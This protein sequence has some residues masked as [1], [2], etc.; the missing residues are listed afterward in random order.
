[1][2]D[3]YIPNLPPMKRYDGQTMRHYTP[4]NNMGGHGEENRGRMKERQPMIGFGESPDEDQGKHLTEE[5]AKRWVSPCARRTAPRGSA[6][7]WMRSSSMLGGFGVEGQEKIVEF[8]A[9]I[10]AMYSDYCKVDKQH[11]VKISTPTWPKRLWMT[12]SPRRIRSRCTRVH[13]KERVTT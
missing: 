8:F 9:V 10:N 1:V 3:A 6:G 7:R 4:Q 2:W 13:R 12:P 5:Q 11:G